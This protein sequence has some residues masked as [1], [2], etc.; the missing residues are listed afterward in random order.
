[1]STKRK[2]LKDDLRR[3]FAHGEPVEPG[4][5]TTTATAPPPTPAPTHEPELRR[6]NQSYRLPEPLVLRLQRVGLRRKHAHQKPWSGQ[7]LV[8]EALTQWLDAEEKR[9]TP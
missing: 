5:E 8:A 3:R 7:D 1:M 6:L 9:A 4:R 2:P